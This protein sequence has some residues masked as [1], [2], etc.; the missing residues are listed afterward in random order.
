MQPSRA[1]SGG[2][3]NLIWEQEVAGSNP[4]IP[5]TSERYGS[6]LKIHVGAKDAI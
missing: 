6:C 1:V 5:T 3:Q 4:A 2:Q